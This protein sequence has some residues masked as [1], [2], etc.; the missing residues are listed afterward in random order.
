[1]FQLSAR[2]GSGVGRAASLY[3]LRRTIYCVQ[4]QPQRTKEQWFGRAK[5]TVH[6]ASAG[7]RSRAHPMPPRLHWVAATEPELENS[8]VMGAAGRRCDDATPLSQASA[9][10]R[11]L[12]SS[13]LDPW[14]DFEV[15]GHGSPTKHI[16][17]PACCLPATHIS[18]RP[19]SALAAPVG[20]Q[21]SSL[22]GGHLSNLRILEL[23]FSL[24]RPCSTS[25]G[26]ALGQPSQASGAAT[27]A[28][29]RAFRLS[30]RPRI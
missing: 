21:L 23:S 8:S 27:S 26:F 30:L 25:G 12:G 18:C 5:T 3:F 24:P 22:S 6:P 1:M 15:E 17:S 9:V 20:S 16:V 7:T 29:P 10:R 13:A 4:V 28:S 2:H 11:P 14:R 19:T